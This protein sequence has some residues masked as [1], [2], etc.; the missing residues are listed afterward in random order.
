MYC[1]A[2]HLASQAQ[3]TAGYSIELLSF[4]AAVY[5]NE[6][7]QVILLIFQKNFAECFVLAGFPCFSTIF[8]KQDKDIPCK[9]QG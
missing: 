2:F 4:M 8:I 5:I 6:R 7:S 9:K 1:T 3:N